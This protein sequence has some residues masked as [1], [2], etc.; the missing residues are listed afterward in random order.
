MVVKLLI[1]TEERRENVTAIRGADVLD[2]TWEGGF[3][4]TIEAG[5]I[6]LLSL[7]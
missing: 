3:R 4:L 2:A 6:S 7:S 1:G 5:Q